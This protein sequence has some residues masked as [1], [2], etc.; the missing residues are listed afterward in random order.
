MVGV[1]MTPAIFIWRNVMTFST[2]DIVNHAV[3]II[4]EYCDEGEWNSYVMN[5]YNV[6]YRWKQLNNPE[7]FLLQPYFVVPSVDDFVT[8]VSNAVWL[9]V[10]YEGQK[11]YNEFQK[12]FGGKRDNKASNDA[13]KAAKEFLTKWM[14]LVN[15]WRE[16]EHKY[17]EQM[18]LAPKKGSKNK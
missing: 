4:T 15:E 1:K 2:Q 3:S 18:G 7:F 16:K 6:T 14:P 9:S 11:R 12:P 10:F 17:N 5:F 13:D 8:Q